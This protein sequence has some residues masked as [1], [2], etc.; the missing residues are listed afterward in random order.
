MDRRALRRRFWIDVALAFGAFSATTLTIVA[1]SWIESVFGIE[2]DGGEG[3]LELGI[4]VGFACAFLAS[5]LFAAREW[6]RHRAV[7]PETK[8]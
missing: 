7:A 8:A 6:R 1:P 5:T 4:A 2:P 3:W